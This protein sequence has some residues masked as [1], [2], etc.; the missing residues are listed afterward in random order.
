MSEADLQ[1]PKDILS[2]PFKERIKKL[3]EC[4]KWGEGFPNVLAGN[5]FDRKSLSGLI[6]LASDIRENMEEFQELGPLKGK[7]LALLFY[8]PSTRTSSSF[9]CAMLRLGG[10]V[11]SLKNVKTSSVAKGETL[12]DTVRTLEC[13]CDAVVLRH[14][15]KGTAVRAAKVLKCPIF[16]AGDGAGE[17]PTQALLDTFTIASE[18]KKIDGL[19]I[20]MLGDLKHGRT[21]HSLANTLS[22]FKIKLNYVSPDFLKMPEYVKKVVSERKVEQAEFETLDEVLKDTDVLY[23]TRVQKERFTGPDGMEQYKK[24]QGAYVI[25]PDLLKRLNAKEKMIV[26]H[27]LPRVGEIDPA[28][29]SDPRAAYFREMRY[30]M[31]MRMA[32]LL[33]SFTSS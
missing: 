4:A 19:T 16:N 23:V 22:H 9:H 15:E 28:L 25:T 27:P 33:A 29:D 18:M 14:P 32:L 26:M 1:R 12:E 10:Q 30:G 24:A 8:E 17:H 3:V 5:Q 6:H 31:I 11:L 21:V 2:M 13:Y 20:T 7:I